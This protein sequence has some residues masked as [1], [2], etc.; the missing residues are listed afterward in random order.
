MMRLFS[1]FVF[2]VVL[3]LSILQPSICLSRP[4]PVT[5]SK[6]VVGNGNIDV[7]IEQKSWN[8][9][10]HFIGYEVA[11]T[12]GSTAALI[13]DGED[14]AAL[15]SKL[16]KEPILLLNGFGVGSFHQ[17]RLI[18]QLLQADSERLVYGIDYLGQGRSWPV[19]CHDGD[20]VNEKGLVYSADTWI[21]QI[22]QFIEQVILRQQPQDNYNNNNNNYN[23]NYNNYNTKIHLVGNSVGGYLAVALAVR[24]PDLISTI[25][26][27]NATPVWGLNL[28]GWDGV[29]P[30]P[31]IP[32]W[33]GRKA[34]DFI[35]D[36]GTIDKYLNTAYA[37]SNAYD[38]LLVR[39][40][41][42]F[43]CFYVTT[44]THHRFFPTRN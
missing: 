13:E 11:T 40:F 10:G 22:I 4:N 17:H 18:P 20:S 9:K 26:L 14:T 44:H 12:K 1:V 5:S 6:T 24:R 33:I 23:N 28:P 29:L 42:S 16:T 38:E 21:D 32:R 2:V 43:L 35:R 3:L 34:F 8:Y 7:N 15:T 31:S 37:N 41:F 25:S 30:P 27:L 36:L 39:F 19:D